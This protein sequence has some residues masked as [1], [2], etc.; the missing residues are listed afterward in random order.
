MNN[1]CLI[2]QI[3]H[4]WI[5]EKICEKSWHEYQHI[6]RSESTKKNL[7]SPFGDILF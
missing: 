1:N 6:F 7:M 4:K 5:I 2:L 3:F